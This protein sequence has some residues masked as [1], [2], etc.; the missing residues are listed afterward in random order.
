MRLP[1]FLR[2]K[3]P[4]QQFLTSDGL[5]ASDLWLDQPDAHQR[6][7]RRLGAGEIDGEQ[8]ENLRD[9]VDK[10]YMVIPLSVD[11][12]VFG[13]VEAAVERLWRDKADDVAYAYHSQLR[14]FTCAQPEHRK[15]SYRIAD[16]HTYSDEALALYLNREV[17]DYLE[18]IFGE[19]VIATQSL[20]F[21]WGS[22]QPLHRDPVYVRMTP[23]SHLLAAWIALEDI[24]PDCGPLIYLPGSH[25]LP[26][27]QYEPGRYTF[28]FGK[29]GD[30]ETLASQEWDR[31]KCAGA[32][33]ELETLTCKRGD[34][35]IWH[36]SLLHGGSYPTDPGLT[37]K[38]FVVHYST[39]AS[40][41]Q[42][43][44]SYL[45][46]T[47]DGGETPHVMSSDRVLERDGCRGFDSPLHVHVSQTAAVSG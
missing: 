4:E 38:S 28:D 43:L 42:V 27:Y 25:R 29:D 45:F 40:M 44:N 12:A 41:K 3:H 21:E 8:A 23:P 10:G 36:H 16:L 2:R 39:T 47:P 14:P 34:V 26:Y 18:L 24:G 20:C 30:K 15:P 6:I 37:R 13:G 32:G 9:F 5:L 11:P 19:P 33:L 22:Q 17:F 46:P 7:D 31:K 35:L 1:G